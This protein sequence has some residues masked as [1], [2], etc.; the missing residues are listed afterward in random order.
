[1]GGGVEV[2]DVAVVADVDGEAFAS[3]AM[4][5]SVDGFGEAFGHF[6]EPLF[7]EGGVLVMVFVLL[8]LSTQRIGFCV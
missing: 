2:D 4:D 6:A 8:H 3:A 1:M 5:L 7:N